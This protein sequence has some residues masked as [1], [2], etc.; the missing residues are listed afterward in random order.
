MKYFYLSNI[1][2]AGLLLLTQYVVWYF[3][4]NKVSKYLTSAI[5]KA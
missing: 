2:H 4:L 3:Y 1:C 5:L